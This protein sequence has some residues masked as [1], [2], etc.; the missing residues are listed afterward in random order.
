MVEFYVGLFFFV[1]AQTPIVSLIGFNW[2]FQALKYMQW[3]GEE[4]PLLNHPLVNPPPHPPAPLTPI[5]YAYT[6]YETHEHKPE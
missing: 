6:H 5:T 4:I 2:H 3:L 1:T